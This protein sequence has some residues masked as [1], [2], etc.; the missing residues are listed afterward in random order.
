M[1]TRANIN[2]KVGNK[3][4]CTSVNYDGYPEGAGKTLHEHYSTQELAEKLVSFG[5]LSSLG[6]SCEQ[7]L[8]HTYDTP[9]RGY[10]V[11]YGRDRGET[12]TEFEVHDEPVDDEGICYVWNGSEW[13]VTCVEYD[14]DDNCH[15]YIDAPIPVVLGEEE[16]ED[17]ND[18]HEDES[19]KIF[20]F[21][22]CGID[23]VQ[24]IYKEW[25][26]NFNVDDERMTDS[27]NDRN[28]W[29]IRHRAAP[30]QGMD[31]DGIWHHTFF[32][33]TLYEAVNRA[34]EYLERGKN[35][36][37]NRHGD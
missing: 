1:G 7:P 19:A 2:V 16:S 18:S 36:E 9:V 3:Y 34:N 4:H 22:G 23:E 25:D 5:E 30:Y 26:V 27:W 28:R 8:G 33:R 11:Y 13:T 32:G 37:D 20:K 35:F 29:M 6:N 24:V 12:G 21:F 14:E 17:G 15:E 10:C 31:E